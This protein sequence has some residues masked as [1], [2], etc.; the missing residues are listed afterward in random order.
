MNIWKR[1]C[2]QCGKEF[3]YVDRCSW[4]QANKNNTLCSECRKCKTWKRLCSQCG[5]EIYECKT[6]WA[7]GCKGN[8]PCYAC[9][10]SKIWKR[11]CPQCGKELFYKKTD[12]A[13][14]EKKNA[15]C[16]S[17][18]KKG[19][20]VGKNNPFYGKHHSVSTKRKLS[21]AN[22]GF[23]QSADTIKKKSQASS[24]TSNPMFGKS[25]YGVWL[26][27]Y[28]KEE[29]DRR[30][31]LLR[32]KLRA[33]ATGENNPMYG[34][35]APQGSGN[36]WSG[37]YKDAVFFRSLR[38]LAFV[39]S[40]DKKGRVWQP[41]ES[42]KIPY[43][44]WEGHARTYRPD[45]IVDGKQVVEVKPVRLHRSPLVQLKCEA[46]RNFCNNHNLEFVL[47][48]PPKLSD[49]DIEDMRNRGT[50]KFTKRYEEKFKERTKNANRNQ[51]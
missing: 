2:P 42:M 41:A 47:V 24:G 11:Q 35:P 27:K 32:K 50:I 26:N 23:V 17:C 48:D 28:G 16:R 18:A 14:A 6:S 19:V 8:I 10:H 15:S 45:F 40:L 39:V 22:T 7:K 31:G 44:D 13:I 51:N 30:L 37:W 25:V 12:L 36:G 20:Y 3:I 43:K 29:A 38:E 1:N 46:A 9:R 21:K 4:V 5:K 34:K 33:N 49:E